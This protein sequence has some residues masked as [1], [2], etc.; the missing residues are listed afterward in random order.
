MVAAALAALMLQGLAP[1]GY[2]PGSLSSGW[3]VMLCPE[4]L[5]KGFLSGGHHHHGHHQAAGGAADHDPGLGEH[6][7]LGGML[8]GAAL[9]SLAITAD[10]GP[11]LALDRPALYAAPALARGNPAH[12]SRAPPAT[13]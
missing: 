2:M 6:C 1:P 12:P 4:G 7:P 11:L 9:S 5:P 10:H 8:D 13:V 3:P